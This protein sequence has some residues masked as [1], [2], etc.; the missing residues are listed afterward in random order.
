MQVHVWYGNNNK[1]TI[2][3]Q[4]IIM[5]EKVKWTTL[6]SLVY[7]VQEECGSLV[8]TKE[9]ECKRVSTILDFVPDFHFHGMKAP[10]GQTQNLY[11]AFNFCFWKIDIIMFR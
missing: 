5:P 1:T 3:K 2:V 6:L 9:G 10:Y 7:M 11:G 8:V 4:A